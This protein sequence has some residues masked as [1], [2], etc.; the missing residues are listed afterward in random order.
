MKRFKSII[1]ITTTIGILLLAIMFTGC[2]SIEFLLE[3][4]EKYEE[5]DR[6][7][8]EA[9]AA[10]KSTEVQRDINN[11]LNEEVAQLLEV[12]EDE[13]NLTDELIAADGLIINRELDY[14]TYIGRDG[15]SIIGELFVVK[16]DEDHRYGDVLNYNG[17]KFFCDTDDICYAAYVKK[18]KVLG[19]KF[20]AARTEIVKL[21]G[22]PVFS[23][24][25]FQF[26]SYQDHMIR[27]PAANNEVKHCIVAKDMNGLVAYM[28]S[29]NE[30]SSYNLAMILGGSQF[31]TKSRLGPAQRESLGENEVLHYDY[32]GIYTMI[33]ENQV[34]RVLI[35]KYGAFGI[36][37]GV[38]KEFLDAFYI[39]P[40]IKADY[41]L[42]QYEDTYY[43]AFF[44]EDIVVGIQI[45]TENE[46]F[47][48]PGE[49]D[50]MSWADLSIN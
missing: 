25:E 43:S 17:N 19:I 40:I 28:A 49:S 3:Q 18:D 6:L 44:E 32:Q 35:T 48:I 2:E 16:R 12:E 13:I 46:S 23:N 30:E 37:I 27:V 50:P 33:K 8:A 39:K 1:K 10:N 38:S 47:T 31:E 41:Y 5:E 26:Y 9:E 15:Q 45:M 11:E 22:P 14:E 21:M 4:N 7:E 20:P 29:F 34:V 24:D 42:Y 36:D